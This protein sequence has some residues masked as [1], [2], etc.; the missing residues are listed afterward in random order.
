MFIYILISL[1]VEKPFGLQPP[2][3]AANNLHKSTTKCHLSLRVKMC[4]PTN[5]TLIP[6]GLYC[7]SLSFIRINLAVNIPKLDDR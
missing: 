4:P 7:L 2:I 1:F 3:V 6:K 5:L